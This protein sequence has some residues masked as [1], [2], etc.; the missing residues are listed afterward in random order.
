MEISHI[1]KSKDSKKVFTLDAG[2]SIQQAASEM[3]ERNFGAVLVSEEAKIKGIFTERDLMRCVASHEGNLRETPLKEV[4]TENPKTISSTQNI[5]DA[6]DMM[7]EGRFRHLPVTHAGK[8]VGIIS[9][10]DI[11]K[12]LIPGTGRNSG[13]RKVEG[14][15]SHNAGTVLGAFIFVVI[16]FILIIGMS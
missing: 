15:L 8:L 12:W 9:Y 16:A 2:I 7:M 5:W 3:A 6:F 11:I 10:I 13:F 14:F 1:I 4:M